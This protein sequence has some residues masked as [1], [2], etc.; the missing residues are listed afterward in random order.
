[1]E[2]VMIILAVQNYLFYD[3]YS[4]FLHEN[5]SNSVLQL[6]GSQV[7]SVSQAESAK[8]RPVR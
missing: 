6:H 5:P 3:F 2:Y 1:M 8:L 4:L 7:E